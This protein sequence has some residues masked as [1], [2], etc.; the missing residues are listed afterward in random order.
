MAL[1][2]ILLDLDET[3]YAP[4]DALIRTVD[5]RITAYIALQTGLSWERSDDLRRDLWRQFGTTARGL[6]QLFDLNERDL[7][8]FA[9]DSVDPDLHI[10]RDPALAVHLARMPAPCYVFTNATRRYAERVLAAL[11]V[12]EHIQGIFDIEF[13]LFNP[14]PA[15]V[16]YQRVVAALGVP[17]A[18]IALVD[19]NAGNFGP[20]LDM[21]MRCVC[22]GRREAPAGVV[23]VSRF[24]D[25]PEALAGDGE[26]GG[27]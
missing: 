6:N 16:F 9:V 1:R 20:A 5:A 19:D 10:E 13:S 17:P 24:A 26:P 18:A 12:S 2:A 8:G 7:Y 4:G 22:V 15:P 23:C 14:K 21:G 25:V 11:G 27:P 3:L